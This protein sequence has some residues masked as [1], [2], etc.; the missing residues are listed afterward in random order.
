MSESKQL[1]QT[2]KKLCYVSLVLLFVCK[3]TYGD[4]LTSDERFEG[5]LVKNKV[6]SDA[7]MGL[8]FDD[9]E[10]S[11]SASERRVLVMQKRYIS[12]ETLKRDVVPCTRPGSSYY[13]CHVAAGQANPYTRGCEVITGCARNIRS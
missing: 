7:E 13:S 5:M 11:E 10:E 12:Y 8:C 9:E 6:C 1:I 2:K 4:L 3:G